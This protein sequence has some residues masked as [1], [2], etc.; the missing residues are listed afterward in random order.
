MHA[1]DVIQ[2]LVDEKV[3][4]V[5]AFLWQQQLRFYWQNQTLDTEIRICD[6]KTKYWYKMQFYLL[7]KRI[8]NVYQKSFIA[9]TRVYP[10]NGK[11]YISSKYNT[12]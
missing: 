7:L 10:F 3:E 5:E 9:F 4:G 6:F 2:K 12:N 8:L 1:R 11:W